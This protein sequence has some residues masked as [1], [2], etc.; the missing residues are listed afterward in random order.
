MSMEV[1]YTRRDTHWNPIC[2]REKDQSLPIRAPP[3]L[4]SCHCLLTSPESVSLGL[5]SEN[6]CLRA[7]SSLPSV[8]KG[9]AARRTAALVI[10]YDIS[11][12]LSDSSNSL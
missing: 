12:R 10:S 3:L 8:A 4:T 7:A 9:V 2:V 11:T 6:S 1:E 5:R